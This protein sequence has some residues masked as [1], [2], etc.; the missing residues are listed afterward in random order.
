MLA[1]FNYFSDNKSNG[2]KMTEF[3]AH[4]A[5]LSAEDKAQLKA[6]IEDG[7]LNY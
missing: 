3:R 6:G 4:W 2:Y 1:V 7:T 5:E